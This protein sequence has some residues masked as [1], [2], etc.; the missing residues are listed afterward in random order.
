M[1]EE[2]IR[3]NIYRD[4]RSTLLLCGRRVRAGHGSCGP[5]IKQ[6]SD[7]KLLDSDLK[8]D[9]VPGDRVS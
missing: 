3:A 9:P 1:S 8:V 6:E 7:L 4:A 5:P 2:R